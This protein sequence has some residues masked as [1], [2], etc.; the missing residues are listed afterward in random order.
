MTTETVAE[1]PKIEQQSTQIDVKP[2]DDTPP[3]VKSETNKDN[4]KAF[5]ESR[6]QD[7]KDKE[8]AQKMAVEER[9]RAEALREAMEALVNKP[10]QQYQQQNTYQ[11]EETEEQR[12]ERKVSAALEKERQKYREQEQKE[13]EEARPRQIRQ[14]LP[15]FDVVCSA[16]NLDY[17]DYHYPEITAGFKHMPDSV[18]KWQ[19]VHKAVKRFV[20]STDLKK[21]TRQLEQNATKPQSISSPSTLQGTQ[22]KGPNILSDQQKAANWERMQKQLRG[23]S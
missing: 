22:A 7:R 11:N 17:L 8:I 21:E 3:F 20:P 2:V 18:E 14:A 10:T 4:W 13:A 1:A 15:D 19:A 23:L 12:I 5:K 6:E 9:A 16:S